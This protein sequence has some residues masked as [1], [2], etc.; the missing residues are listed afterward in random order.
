M[1][2]FILSKTTEVT[3]GHLRSFR[4]KYRTAR[5]LGKLKLKIN[6]FALNFQKSTLEVTQGQN[7]R[8]QIREISKTQ[9]I[10]KLSVFDL[11]PPCF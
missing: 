3:R 11:S 1:L 4:V 6:L 8:R 10:L 2:F 7:V 9:K 5:K